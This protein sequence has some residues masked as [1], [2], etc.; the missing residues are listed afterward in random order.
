MDIPQE[1]VYFIPPGMDFSNKVYPIDYEWYHIIRVKDC[2]FGSEIKYVVVDALSH[3]GK[4]NVYGTH[5]EF[6]PYTLVKFYNPLSLID[7]QIIYPEMNFTTENYGFKK[8]MITPE[9]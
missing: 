5:N 6:N 1:V 9:N 4:Y 3:C 2:P 8:L 7:A